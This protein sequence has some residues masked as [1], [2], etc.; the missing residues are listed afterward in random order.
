MLGTLRGSMQIEG[1]GCGMVDTGVEH[2]DGATDRAS[3]GPVQTATV[4]SAKR[5]MDMDLPRG[6]LRILDCAYRDRRRSTALRS[7]HVV[8]GTSQ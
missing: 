4:G 8:L 3:E 2:T 7:R 5:I 6:Q 1:S